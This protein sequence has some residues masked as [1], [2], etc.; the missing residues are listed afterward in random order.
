V[1]SP[2][3]VALDLPEAPRALHLAQGLAPHVGG[4]KVGLEL[5]MAEGPG[6]ID[7]VAALGLPVFADVKLHDIPNTVSAASRELGR[8][9]ARWLTVHGWGG[10]EM[11]AAAVA[12]LDEGATGAAGVLVVTVL[13]SL[14]SESLSAVGIDR[15]VGDQVARLSELAAGA[16]AEG[17]VC[18]VGEISRVK[19]AD[20]DLTVITPGIR[21]SGSVEDDQKRPATL[22]AALAAGADWVVVGR[23]IT[24]ATD[25][26]EAARKMSA[27]AAA[28]L[29]S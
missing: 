26:V 28:N 11:I 14:D 3:L 9:G 24:R 4:F 1:V 5:L 22:E 19:G 16:G 27:E 29:R 13:T 23:P 8:R 20:P 17:V 18:A 25:P 6:V 10:A 2:I 7:E 15:E 12:G 21:P